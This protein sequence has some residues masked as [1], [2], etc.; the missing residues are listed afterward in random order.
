MNVLGL[1]RSRVCK[2]H[3]L[4]TPESFVRSTLPGWDGT[5]IVILIS[6]EMGPALPNTWLT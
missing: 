2:D 5:E 4:I 3:A 6:P 1:T